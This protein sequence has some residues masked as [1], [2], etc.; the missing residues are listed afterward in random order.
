[1]PNLFKINTVLATIACTCLAGN[2]LASEVNN[3]SN[4]LTSNDICPVAVD[5]KKVT[6]VKAPL[7]NRL[8]KLYVEVSQPKQKDETVKLTRLQTSPD[9]DA[10][11]VTLMLLGIAV[12]T[13]LLQ[14]NLQETDSNSTE[15]DSFNQTNSRLQKKL[16]TLV[17]SPETAKRL[18]LNTQNK[19]PERSANWLFEKTIY[20]LERDRRAY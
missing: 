1:M 15:S 3:C 18:F 17:Q 2:V 20:D 14:L 12:V 8:T 11:Q 9:F 6:T 19:Y 16:L 4:N 13:A 5:N 10:T 7:E